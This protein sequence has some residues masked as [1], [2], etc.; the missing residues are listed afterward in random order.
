MSSLVKKAA[1]HWSYVAPLLN[2]PCNETEY[3]WLVRHLDE[4]LDVVGDK[5]GHPLASLASHMGN[6]IEAYDEKHRPIPPVTGS[7]ALRYLMDEHQLSH[8][9]LPEV[10]ARSAVSLILRGKRQINVRQARA[11]ASRFNLPASLFLDL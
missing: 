2:P 6:L 3:G 5:E 8:G 4:I 9:D 10:G 1:E 11:L 7:A